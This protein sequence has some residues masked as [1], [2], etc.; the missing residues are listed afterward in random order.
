MISKIRVENF[1]SIRQAE[2]D[3]NEGF[4]V[5]FGRNGSGKTNLISAIFLLKR[6]VEGADI[7]SVISKMAPFSSEEFFYWNHSKTEASFEI[8]FNNHDSSYIFSYQ[9]AHMRGDGHIK[10]QSE[11]LKKKVAGGEVAIYRRDREASFKGEDDM[12]IP[13]KTDPRKLMLTSFIDEMGET[14]K[15]VNILKRSLFVDPFPKTQDGMQVVFGSKPDLETMDGLA[16]SLFIKNGGRFAKAVD[17]IQKIVPTFLAPTVTPIGGKT[18]SPKDGVSDDDVARYVVLWNEKDID[19][20]FSHH[21]FSH[22]DKRVIYLI[23][24][25][26]NAEEGSFLAAEEIENGMHVGR[27]RKL[28]DVFRTQASNRNIQVLLTTHSLE[29]LEAVIATDAIYATKDPKA[30]TKFIHCQTS[31]DYESFKKDLGREP[32]MRELVESGLMS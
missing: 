27:I 24:S 20:Q 9:V 19:A 17:T 1:R 26:F 14:V 2:V 23:F 30:G 16:V 7:D 28:L 21:S 8:S 11:S 29:M 12:Q 3:L 18:E 6:L 15:A 31:T 5:V 4:N 22:G 25:L 32:T 10:V 13:Y